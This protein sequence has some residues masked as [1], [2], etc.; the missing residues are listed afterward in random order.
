M[1]EDYRFIDKADI[2]DVIRTGAHGDNRSIDL[3]AHDTHGKITGNTIRKWLYGQTKRPQYFKVEAVCDVL[4]IELRPLWRA[5]G[6]RVTVNP[7]LAQHYA[8]IHAN[9]LAK[10]AKIKSAKIKKG[11]NAA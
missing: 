2:I 9:N 4:G 8:T 5:T 11:V 1:A 10:R 7:T 3:I 6:Q